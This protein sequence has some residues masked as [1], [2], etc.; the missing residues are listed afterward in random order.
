MYITLPISQLDGLLDYGLVVFSDSTRIILLRNPTC[1]LEN[2]PYTAVATM[3]PMALK[4]IVCK[5]MGK[6]NDHVCSL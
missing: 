4:G 2:V 1:Q 3:D 6:M 5:A